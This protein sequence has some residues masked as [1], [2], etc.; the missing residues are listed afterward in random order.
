MATVGHV[1]ISIEV[2]LGA[3]ITTFLICLSLHKNI[4]CPYE[5]KNKHHCHP[6]LLPLVLEQFKVNQP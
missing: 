3:R 6:G 5:Q 4:F 2:D 1:A